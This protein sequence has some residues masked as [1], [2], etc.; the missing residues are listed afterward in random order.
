MINRIRLIK[1]RL[2]G[3]RLHSNSWWKILL[4]L[5]FNKHWANNYKVIKV[6]WMIFFKITVTLAD[7]LQIFIN[8]MTKEIDL[9]W[10]SQISFKIYILLIS[11]QK[12]LKLLHLIIGV[13]KEIFWD[14][15][16]IPLSSYYCNLSMELNSLTLNKA[17][18]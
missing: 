8:I 9:F 15:K 5:T 7:N 16:N 18:L 13:L 4:K 12:R 11:F 3:N 1:H 10:L 17:V 14:S 6:I 2:K